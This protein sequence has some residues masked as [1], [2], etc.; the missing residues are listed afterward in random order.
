MTQVGN[1]QDEQDRLPDAQVRGGSQDEGLVESKEEVQIGKLGKHN[2]G[3]SRDGSQ[4][5]SGGRVG[6]EQIISLSEVGVV[7][8][9][10]GRNWLDDEEEDTIGQREAKGNVFLL[11]LLLLLLWGGSHGEGTSENVAQRNQV[12][13]LWRWRS[14]CMRW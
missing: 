3:A 14:V 2:R 8:S 4:N 9:H 1:K 13:V 10:E 5:G 6:Q 7:C 11:L 12:C